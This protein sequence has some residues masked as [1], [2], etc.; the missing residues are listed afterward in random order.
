[1]PFPPG[2]DPFQHALQEV[3]RLKETSDQVALAPRPSSWMPALDSFVTK[4]ELLVR[5]EVPGVSRE[6]LEVFVVDGE[7][8]VRGERKPPQCPGSMRPMAIERPYGAFERR[9]VAPA[10]SRIDQMKARTQDGVLELRIPMKD[11]E[12][13][14]EHKIEVV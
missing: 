2:V 7:C 11:V 9:F 4:D 5:I 3:Q 8:V 13:T 14:K 6:D 1:M 12:F 10:G